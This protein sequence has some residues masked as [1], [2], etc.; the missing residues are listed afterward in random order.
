MTVPTKKSEIL[1]TDFDNQPGVLIQVY[2]DERAHTKDNCQH[3]F[4]T[5]PTKKIQNLLD[6]L[7]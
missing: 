6:R 1:S 3:T 4:M 5:V 7:G 2:E